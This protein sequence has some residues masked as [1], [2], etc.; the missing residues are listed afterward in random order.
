M[1]PARCHDSKQWAHAPH[2]EHGGGVVHA[3]AHHRLGAVAD[4]HGVAGQGR[5]PPH[6]AV[7]RA[8]VHHG[9]LPLCSG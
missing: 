8:A 2:A 9:G 5:G 6:H 7:Y 4:E 3:P 1:Q